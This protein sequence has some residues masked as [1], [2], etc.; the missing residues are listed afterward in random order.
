MRDRSSAALR[1]RQRRSESPQA[2]ACKVAVKSLPE[3]DQEM[4][5]FACSLYAD[6]EGT[7]EEVLECPFRNCFFVS[8][9]LVGLMNAKPH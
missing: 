8:Y 9:G 4:G 7:A 2:G 5:M 1:C 6:L 3:K